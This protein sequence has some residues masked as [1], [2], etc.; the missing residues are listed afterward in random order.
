MADIETNIFIDPE[1]LER[2]LNQLDDAMTVTHGSYQT[3]SPG[4]TTDLDWNH[5]DPNHRQYIHRTYGKSL[6]ICTGADFQISLTKYGDW[7]LLLPVADV[8]LRPGLFYQCFS[9]F[10]L[11]T[12]I[13][14]LRTAEHNGGAAQRIDWYIVSKRIWKFLHPWLNRKMAQLNRIQNAEDE[15]IR[16]R[17]F[18]LRKLGFTFKSDRP[19]FLIS[20]SLIPNLIP[21]HLQHEHVISL[22]QTDGTERFK[23]FS[24]ENLSFLYVYDQHVGVHIWPEACPH[25]GGPLEQSLI[26]PIDGC[27]K[28]PWHGLE[29]RSVHLTRD[30]PRGQCQGTTVRLESDTIVVSPSAKQNRPE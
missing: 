1:D 30:R 6:R 16:N 18:G 29:I 23:K 26:H 4:L 12:V 5:M 10:S 8:R 24:V 27:L 25:E 20:S 19:D 11:A 13:A 17:R 28:C 21:P 3:L 9:V 22:L 14:V 7:P 15:P 2:Q